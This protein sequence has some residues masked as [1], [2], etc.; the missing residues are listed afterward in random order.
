LFLG[1]F[2]TVFVYC[3][4]LFLFLCPAVLFSLLHYVRNNSYKKFILCAVVP[5]RSCSAI[6]LSISHSLLIKLASHSS[7]HGLCVVDIERNR[8]FKNNK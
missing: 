8:D 5:L 3:S 6:D 1:R 7:T 4:W 2:V